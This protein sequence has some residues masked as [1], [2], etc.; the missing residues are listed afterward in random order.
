MLSAGTRDNLAAGVHPVNVPSASGGIT[1]NY[2]SKFIAPQVR[3][4]HRTDCPAACLRPSTVGAL[5]I[6]NG[7]LENDGPNRK[8]GTENMALTKRYFS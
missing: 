1:G 8:S 6:G 3:C 7:Q 4:V 2:S 5:D